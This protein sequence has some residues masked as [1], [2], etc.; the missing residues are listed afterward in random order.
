MGNQKQENLIRK[1]T[2]SR[3]IKSGKKSQYLLFLNKYHAADIAE[4]LEDFSFE[5]KQQ[6]FQNIN[7]EIGAD[8]IEEMQLQD[9]VELINQLKE[10]SVVKYVQ[11]MDTD[12]AVDLLEELQHTDEE[13]AESIINALPKK[14]AQDIKHLLSYE[15]GTAGSIMNLE[16]LSI[17]EDLTVEE[18]I[19][20][21]KQKDPPEN[22]SSYFVFIINNN[23][24]LMGYTTLRTL[25]LS[26]PQTKI[27]AIRN[28]SL[29]IASIDDDQEE[30]AL[31]FKKYNLIVMPVIDKAS[32]LVGLI[33][34][35]DIIDVVDEE[36]AE[37][38]FRLTGTSDVDEDK[39]FSG[40]ILFSVFSRTP[41]LFIT[42]GGGI[43]ASYIITHFSS[44]YNEQHFPLALTLS[45]VPL[46]MGLGGNVGNQAATI[47]VR[48]IATDQIKEN[49]YTHHFIK[50]VFI[51]LLMGCIISGFVFVIN[52]L[53]NLPFLFC[54]I[55][56]LALIGN[57]TIASFLGALLPILFKKMN[58]DPAVASAPFISTA[59]DILGQ[60]IYFSLTLYI[61]SKLMI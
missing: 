4:D 33:T 32:R 57:I 39:I 26:D 38:I 20:I 14:E 8:I 6:F 58:I 50:E 29:I 51:G 53:S 19:S 1:K 30:V 40:S 24:E 49:K 59:L 22:E 3:L 5:E 37:D 41:W 21:I 42:I 44:L 16:Y 13:K 12:D 25:L 36:A 9:Q 17:P 60:L 28:E 27:K 43:L 45:F 61:F 35:D 11:E 47:F 48:G 10:E 46:L 56:S 54:S 31:Q 2:L 23:Y 55:V 34:V 7:P 15:E 18:T 52:I